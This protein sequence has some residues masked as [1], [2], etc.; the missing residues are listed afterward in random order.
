MWSRLNGTGQ[1][2]EHRDGFT[3]APSGSKMTL[4]TP[5]LSPSFS[6]TNSPTVTSQEL[7]T[8]V[9]LVIDSHGNRSASNVTELEKAV[10]VLLSQ[11]YLF[12][13][14]PYEPSG[15]GEIWAV[16]L[17]SILLFLLPGLFALVTYFRGSSERRASMTGCVQGTR[18]LC[19]MFAKVFV[20]FFTS[21][22]RRD[23]DLDRLGV[24]GAAIL[25]FE[26]ELGRMLVLLA[27]LLNLTLVPVHFYFGGEGANLLGEGRSAHKSDFIAW[28]IQNVPVKLAYPVLWVHIVFVF[29]LTALIFA[30]GRHLRRG[31]EHI[32]RQHQSMTP[33][34]AD[35]SRRQQNACSLFVEGQVNFFPCSEHDLKRAFE[36]V[37]P[38]QIDSIRIFEQRTRLRSLGEF[39]SVVTFRTPQYAREFFS[40]R[41]RKAT[42]RARFLELMQGAAAV[43]E[44]D[45]SSQTKQSLPDEDITHEQA[46]L[47]VKPPIVAPIGISGGDIISRRSRSSHDMEEEESERASLKRSSLEDTVQKRTSEPSAFDEATFLSAVRMDRWTVQPAPDPEDLI[48]DALTVDKWAFTCR[49][50]CVNVLLVI[51]LCIFTTP[52]AFITFASGVASPQVQNDIQ[53]TYTKFVGE[54]RL[55][56]PA[57]GDFLFGFLPQLLLVICDAWLLFALS[58]ASKSIEPHHTHS[59]REVSLFRKSFW[60]LLFN[61]LL[62]PSLALSSIG[63]FVGDL[64]QNEVSPFA[65]LGRAFATS[66]GA[67][68]LTFI[69]TQTWVGASMDVTRL[70]ERLYFM[71]RGYARPWASAEDRRQARLA[72]F[73]FDYG[74]EY[75]LALT[76]FS[77][78]IVFATVAPPILIFGV[79][80]FI[81]KQATDDHSL[82]H[83]VAAQEIDH[84][85]RAHVARAALRHLA[86]SVILLQ[87]SLFGFFSTEVCLP[88]PRNSTTPTGVPCIANDYTGVLTVRASFAQ[89]LALLVCLVLTCVVVLRDLLK[90]AAALQP[91]S[92]LELASPKAPRQL[93]TFATAA[94]DLET[95]TRASEKPDLPKT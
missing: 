21:M 74:T 34:A 60:F 29:L 44:A 52:I 19:G 4:A 54:L 14:D 84:L 83:I 79:S 69:A 45:S 56:S 16:V 27:F 94:S 35:E 39:R 5:T 76:M 18:T 2:S 20:K 70:S 37:A 1:T 89:I 77:L 85:P 51:G 17:C 86:V 26:R 58:L 64:F 63:A 40:A 80:Y 75:A 43:S 23:I 38:G 3:L 62:L 90:S 72:K 46:S 36:S 65:L 30:F 59:G 24:E 31:F 71:A 88:Q 13:A 57:L 67:F 93:R 10:G 73:E 47:V 28:T 41:L 6:R 42:I 25:F 87:S 11:G 53:S 55:L 8:A 61:T 66:S 9:S 78:C 92:H 50:F 82:R 7:E 33:K 12:T 91:L 81:V 32:E 68:T 48:W 95:G 49:S 15:W 22:Q